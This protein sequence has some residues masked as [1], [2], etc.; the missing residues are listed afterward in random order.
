MN[1]TPHYTIQSNV[2]LFPQE[3]GWHFIAVPQKIIKELRVFATRGLIPVTATIGKSTW[4]TSL[5][6]ETGGSTYF[7]PLNAKIRK[8][9]SLAAGD[10]V[11]VTFLP[12]PD[13]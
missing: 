8:Q 2:K 7:I 5:M 4:R 10:R 3:G 1:Q 6:P 11:T 13:Q 9:E 12:T